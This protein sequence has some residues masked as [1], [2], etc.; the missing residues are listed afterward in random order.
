MRTPAPSRPRGRT[1]GAGVRTG[2]AFVAVVLV[3]VNLRPGASSVGPVLEEVTTGLGTGSGVAGVLTGLPGLCFGLVGA[4]AVTIARRVGTTTG[5]AAGITLAATALLLRGLT[6]TSWLFLVL[7]T[8]ALAGM[9]VGNVLVPAWIKAHA[10]SDTVL[11]PTVYG[12]SLIVGGTIGSALTAPVEAQVGWSRALAMW[13]LVA[14]LAVPVWAWLALRERSPSPG[15]T[16]SAVATPGGRIF[17][18]PTAVAMA[19]LFGVQSMH[20]YVQFGWLPQIYRDAGLSASSAGAMQAMLTAFGIVGALLMPTVIARSRTLAP[21]MIAFGAALLLGYAGL[22]V[23]PATLPWLW[24][25]L[26]GFS[27][28]AFP[29]T[30]AMLTARTRDHRVTARLSGFVQPAG[31]LFAAVGPVVVGLIHSATGS[32]T[33]PLVLLAATVVPFTWAGLRVSRPVYVD[34]ELAS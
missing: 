33:V 9:A 20:A 7:S 6:D 16:A 15:G 18:S 5:I 19:T 10:S 26:L 8:L 22:L 25:L 17:H 3:A 29:A 30:I 14:L 27:G 12:T 23:D 1:A 31:Y 34:D 24:A 4:I 2:V 13:G 21:W 28:F 11:L 32:W